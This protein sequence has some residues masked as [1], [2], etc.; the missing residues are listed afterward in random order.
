MRQLV[1]YLLIRHTPNGRQFP[2]LDCW[3]LVVD[4]YREHLGIT[5][6][7]Y[8]DLDHKTMSK[9]LLYE[10]QAGR[11]IEVQSPIDYDVVAFFVSGRLYHVG[12]WIRGKILHTSERRGCRWE[13]IDSIAL[14][15]R[16]FYRY[17]KCRGGQ[18]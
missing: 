8:T 6:D 2:N 18:P 5:L 13:K 16:R 9:G 10:R 14:S 17:D 12:V 11:F 1:D 7:D 15:Q 4:V 3:G